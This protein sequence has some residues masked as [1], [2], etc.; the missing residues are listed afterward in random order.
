M[1]VEKGVKIFF[2]LIDREQVQQIFCRH[3]EPKTE[4]GRIPPSSFHLALNDLSIDTLPDKVSRLFMDADIDKDGGLDLAE[5]RRVV[6]RPSEIEQWSSTLPLAKLLGCC[7]EAQVANSVAGGRDMASP[8]PLRGLC[9]LSPQALDSAAG[10]FSRGLRRLLAERASLLRRCY[11]GLDKRAVDGSDGSSAKFQSFTMAAGDAEDFHKGLTDRVGALGAP[12]TCICVYLW[13]L[14][15]LTC[16]VAGEP[17]PDLTRGM[18]EEHCA[19]FGWDEEFE[20]TN[21]GVRT[22]PRQEYEIAHG[23]RECPAQNMLDKKGKRVRAIR[24]LDDLRLVEAVKRGGLV[25]E[26]I[27]AVVRGSS[28][29]AIQRTNLT[30]LSHGPLQCVRARSRG[31]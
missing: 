8:D 7:L 14:C 9:K 21:Y 6:N 28:S 4:G 30:N 11:E 3:A 26:E 19:A 10:E 2:D 5:F 24:S 15:I 29:A 1:A 27:V 31:E 17:H 20:T 22:T 16:R 13:Y 18:R 23:E 12:A 25:D